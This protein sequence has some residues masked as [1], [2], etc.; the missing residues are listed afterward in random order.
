MLTIIELPLTAITP[1]EQNAKEHPKAQIEQIRRSIESFGMNDPLAIDEDNVIIEGHGRYLALKDMS[2]DTVPCIRL[3]HLSSEQKRAYILAHNKL[4]LNTGFD[5]EA[6]TSELDFLRGLDFD[7]SLTGFSLDE[8]EKLFS[9]REKD[10]KEDDFDV[11]AALAAASFAQKGDL[12]T[13][14][15]HRLYVGDA[16]DAG[17]VAALM[18]DRKANLVVTDP[19]YGVTYQGFEG[20]K[21]DNDAMK[22]AE[23]AAFLLAAFQNMAAS[24]EPGG[25]AYVFHAD[26][27]GLIFRQAF[28]DA[29]F[30]LS[31][32]CV[33]VKNNHVLGRSPYQWRHEPILFGW[34]K[35]GNH[36]WLAGRSEE[37]VWNFNMPT[38]THNHPTSKPLDLCA[39]PIKN[40]CPVNGIVLDTFG[41]SGSTLLACEQTDR[42]CHMMELDDKYASVILRRYAAY[43]GSGADI[44]CRRD[45]QTLAYDDLVVEP[46]LP[47]TMPD[48]KRRNRNYHAGV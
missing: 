42:A 10:V 23:F 6:L 16:T 19:P 37:T 17:D 26:S 12:W 13:L 36:R 25:T 20:L 35:N 4:T 11:N 46:D 29:G 7:V 18:G 30:Y 8:I 41:G 43:K 22:D 5:L 3:T 34:L 48:V 1:F 15:R 45:G 47:D 39:Y 14:G 21:I 33:W 24:L 40:S 44:T 9:A 28:G 31:Q 27:R 32:V 2:A 38:R